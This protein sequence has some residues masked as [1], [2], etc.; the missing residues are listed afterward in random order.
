MV[1]PSILVD[2][3]PRGIIEGVLPPL[4]LAILFALLPLILRGTSPFH[5]G[6]I[7]L[8]AAFSPC[9]VRVHPALLSHIRQRLPAFLLLLIDVGVSN[10]HCVPLSNKCTS[11]GFLIVTLTSGIADGKLPYL[12]RPF[13]SDPS[14]VAIAGVCFPSIDFPLST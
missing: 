10:A 9:V 4:L 12:F 3:V 8:T 11:H 7:D 13:I 1:A 14:S 2:Q 5:A 6:R